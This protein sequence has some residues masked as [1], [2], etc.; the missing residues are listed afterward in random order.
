MTFRA[1]LADTPSPSV[2]NLI[3]GLDTAASKQ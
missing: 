2:Y 1:A 3:D